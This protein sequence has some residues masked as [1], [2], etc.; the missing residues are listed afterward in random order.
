M[1][2]SSFTRGLAVL[3]C[4]WLTRGLDVS[5]D[6]YTST[7]CNTASTITP[8]AA[9]NL[10]ICVVT[11]GLV[12]LHYGTVPC[13]GGGVVVPFLF[14]DTSCGSQQSSL[15]FY[16]TG[17]DFHCL[18]DFASDTIAAIMLSCNQNQPE[19]PQGT[20]TIS[21]AQVAT[22]APPK[23]PTSSPSGSNNNS[24]DSQTI[25]TGW[26]SLSLGAHV[27]IIVAAAVVA[28]SLSV[29]CLYF[30]KR[31]YPSPRRIDQH[32]YNDGAPGPPCT[33]PYA[34]IHQPLELHGR[35]VPRASSVLP[36]TYLPSELPS[37]SNDTAYGQ[38]L[39]NVVKTARQHAA[40]V[41]FG[42][43]SISANDLV[44][45]VDALLP[46]VISAAFA[47]RQ[48]DDEE[49]KHRKGAAGELYVR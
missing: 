26:N 11:P 38:V 46:G 4:A 40:S 35:D 13:A 33:V 16:K 27:G 29:T 39:E 9:L 19:Q 49:W 12:S 8:S 17:S 36:P 45:P 34:T 5:L 44:N 20:S 7:D 32:Y 25:Q 37:S 1:L 47:K 3:S 21:V 15:D 48:Q 41:H 18:S 31:Q 14:G 42:N 2:A 24:S 30:R 22:G 10:S 6:F 43:G 23:S 28:L